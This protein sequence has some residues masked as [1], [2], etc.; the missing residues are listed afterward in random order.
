MV[1]LNLEI[2]KTINTMNNFSKILRLGKVLQVKIAIA[3]NHLSNKR[4]KITSVMMFGQSAYMTLRLEA[5]IHN[6][7]YLK[8][9]IHLLSFKIILWIPTINNLYKFE[10]S[11]II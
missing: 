6:T 8:C 5:C 11:I 1:Y 4:Y 3:R 9:K 2:V 7:L 10:T